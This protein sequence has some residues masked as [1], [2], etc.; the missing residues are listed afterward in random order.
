MI[1]SDMAGAHS[2]SR[3]S[4]QRSAR[5]WGAAAV[6]APV[7]VGAML[8]SGGVAAADPGTW[9]AASMDARG[10]LFEARSTLGQAD[11]IAK[12][13]NQCGHVC[14]EPRSAQ[15]ACIALAINPQNG[16]G[17]DW[18]H[19]RTEAEHRAIESSQ[20]LYHIPGPYRLWS[21]CA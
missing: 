11:V 18:G 19:T 10:H 1:H 7:S 15:N 16:W 8:L 5:R 4:G 13:Q 20:T 14:P 2:I 12:V 21:D 6:L 17:S 3:S 9:I